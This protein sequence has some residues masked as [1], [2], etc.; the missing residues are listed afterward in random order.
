MESLRQVNVLVLAKL[1]E[2]RGIKLDNRLSMKTLREQNR[3]LHKE[4]ANLQRQVSHLRKE[5]D[6]HGRLL[7]EH[8]SKEQTYR[9]ALNDAVRSGLTPLP[10]GVGQA[11]DVQ[12]MPDMHKLAVAS[13][14]D[15]CHVITRATT[16]KR[17]GGCRSVSYCSAQC[18]RLDWPSHK[19]A[20]RPSATARPNP[21]GSRSPTISSP[22][23]ATGAVA[24]DGGSQSPTVS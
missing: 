19:Q 17:C 8:Q 13:T 24:D 21:V 18:Q 22:E 15:Y 1:A 12:I 7:A 3:A 11:F 20:C 2:A 4:V 23:A 9:L 10:F 5:L 14:C 6:R 16:W